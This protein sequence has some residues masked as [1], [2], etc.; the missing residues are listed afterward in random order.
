M[1]WLALPN[2]PY[3]GFQAGI[4]MGFENLHK[5]GVLSDYLAYSYLVRQ[6]ELGNHENA[7]AELFETVKNFSPDVIFIAHPGA[8]Y[9]MDV[10]YIRKLKGIS[11]KP[12]LVYFEGD[13]YDTIIKRINPTMKALFSESD[14]VFMV[15]T[16]SLSEIAHRAGAKNIRL[17]THSYD[18]QRFG[19][20]WTPTKIRTLDA[21]MIANLPCL[22]RIPWLYLPGGRGRKQAADLLYKFLGDRFAVYGGDQGWSKVAYCKGRLPFDQQGK[23]IR[24]AW[25][26]VNWGQYDKIPMYSSDRLQI[27]LASGVP[28]ITNYQPGYEHVFNKAPGLFLINKPAEALDVALYLLSLTVEKRNELGFLAADYAKKHLEGSLVFSNLAKVV[29]E[30]F[31]N[32]TT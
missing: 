6:N 26:S 2:E 13:A 16:G 23:I 30:K 3:I 12:K 27:S 10:E 8:G 11:S 17:V 4:R 1:R 14:M 28:H 5:E 25:M 29:L 22:K 19:T 15:G 31:F 7:L 21:V 20:P 9:P 32:E 24:D 18:S